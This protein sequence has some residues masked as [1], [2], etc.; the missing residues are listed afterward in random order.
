MTESLFE[1]ENDNFSKPVLGAVIS[2][3]DFYL[4]WANRYLYKS[5]Y[6]YRSSSIGKI[7]VFRNDDYLLKHYKY[8]RIIADVWWTPKMIGWGSEKQKKQFLK[9]AKKVGLSRN[10]STKNE[11]YKIIDIVSL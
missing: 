4:K 11:W 5:D 9:E 7:E 10:K 3:D 8:S 2:Y 6:D 1:N